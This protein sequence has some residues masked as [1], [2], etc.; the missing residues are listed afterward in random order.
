MIRYV[1]NRVLC[2]LRLSAQLLAAM[3]LGAKWMTMFA[4]LMVFSLLNMFYFLPHVWWYL[5]SPNIIRCV[6]YRSAQQARRRNLRLLRKRRVSVSPAAR[7]GKSEPGAIESARWRRFSGEQNGVQ[8]MTS[9]SYTTGESTLLGR[10]RTTTTTAAAAAA[11][12][13]GLLDDAAGEKNESEWTSGLFTGCVSSEES[14]DEEETMNLHSRATLDIY[15]PLPLDSLIRMMEKKQVSAESNGTRK[16][17]PIVISV[18]GGAW[19]VGFRFWNFLIA[20]VFAARGYIVF[21][22]DYRNFPQ[23]DMEGMVLDVS[24]AIG[25]V[26]QNAERYGGD[27]KDIT[28]LGQSAGAHLTMMSLLSQAQLH[29]HTV[30]GGLPST[31]VAY[32]VPRYNPRESIRR[33]V[34][35]SGVYNVR[36]LVSHFDKRGLHRRVLYQLAGGRA[37]LSQYSV[38]LYFDDRCCG[39]AGEALAI[40]VFDFLPRCMYFIHGD[41]DCSAPVSESANIALVMRNAQRTRLAKRGTTDGWESRTQSLEPVTV[42]YIVV[43]GATHTDAIVEECLC[44][45]TSHVVDF[46]HHCDLR[47]AKRRLAPSDDECSLDSPQ[48]PDGTLRTPAPHDVR[49][50][51]MRLAS[52]VS[53]F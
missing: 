53:P 48:R 6:S 18:M 45:R 20:R 34:G 46:L 25:W 41:A 23:T 49:P 15:L 29:A 52:F 40:N 14:E 27:P 7:N 22:P 16:K 19:I 5:V 28:L 36:G 47:D 13:V 31:K 44:A 39:D 9:N 30:S 8:R 17:F 43:S 21:C 33:Y 37:K 26:I 32:N 50:L 4:R 24:D 38:N 51:L 42:E 10:Q 12:A 35:L 1:A 2:V 11:A 3:G